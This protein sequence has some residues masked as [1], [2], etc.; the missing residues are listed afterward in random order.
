MDVFLQA[1]VWYMRA[2]APVFVDIITIELSTFPAKFSGDGQG[3]RRFRLLDG[4][5]QNLPSVGLLLKMWTLLKS[6]NF[7]RPSSSTSSCIGFRSR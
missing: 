2:F 7:T 1:V 6:F 3:S 4:V 5:G